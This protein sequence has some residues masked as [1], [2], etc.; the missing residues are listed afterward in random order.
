MADPFGCAAFPPLALPE[1][2]GTISFPFYILF[3]KI[4][5]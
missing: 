4:K 1:V 5:T 3:F 2:S